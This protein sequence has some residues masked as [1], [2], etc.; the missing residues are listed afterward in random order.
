[1]FETPSELTTLDALLD[2]SFERAGSHLTSIISPDRRLSAADLA[3]YLVGVRHLVLATVNAEG[4]PRVSAVDGLFI[5][6]RFW[7]ST[8]AESVKARHLERRPAL[9]AAHVVGDDVGVFVHGEA[10]IVHGGPGE[11]D[12]LRPYWTD[13][14]ESSPEDWV[15][16]PDD[17]RYVEIVPSSMYSY[18]FSRERFD[19][20]CK[21]GASEDT[22]I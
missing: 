3:R 13:V 10:H 1:M 14:Y 15:D 9:S 20:L 21:R 17:A 5:H 8:S 19:E 16:S 22:L 11:A 4:E 6:G 7:F 18:A 2:T 12:E